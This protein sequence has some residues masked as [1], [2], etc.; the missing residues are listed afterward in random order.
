[1]NK[2]GILKWGDYPGLFQGAQ[3][4]KGPHKREAEI[5]IREGDAMMSRGWSDEAISQGLGAVS[6]RC[7]R[8]RNRFSP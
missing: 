1:M 2:L 7:N 3:C 4:N 6:R 5:T 8:R